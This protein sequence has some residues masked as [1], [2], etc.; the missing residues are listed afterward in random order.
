MRGTAQRGQSGWR[1]DKTKRLG[2]VQHDSVNRPKHYN[3]SAIEPIDVIEAWG[4]GFHL[5]NTVK[6][7]ARAE[8]KGS[9]LE[10]LKK[11]RWYL[12]RKIAQLEKGQS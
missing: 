10:D 2:Q 3:F 11:A 6:Y 7:I 1:A 5:G 12:D 4:L 9:A 8:H